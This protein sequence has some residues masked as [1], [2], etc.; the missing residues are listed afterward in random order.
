MVDARAAAKRISSDQRYGSLHGIP[1]AVKDVIDYRGLATTGKSRAFQ[2]NIAVR[3]AVVVRRLKAAGG[4]FFGKLACHE[5]GFAAPSLDLPWPPVRN[6]WDARLSPGGSSSG[7]AAA[8]SAGFVPAALGTDT[9]GSVRSPASSCGVVGLVPTP[10]LVSGVGVLPLSP[11]LDRVGVLAR[12]VEDGALVLRTLVGEPMG[13]RVA[14]HRGGVGVGLSGIRVGY[15]R[16]FHTIDCSDPDPSV[17]ASLE[18]AV[19]LLVE[20]GAEVREV[21]VRLSGRVCRGYQTI[22]LAEAW[23]LYGRRFA[24][25]RGDLG[26]AAYQRLS[27]GGAIGASEYGNAVGARRRLAREYLESTRE[28]DA[29]IC[30]SGMDTPGRLG[31][32]AGTAEKYARQGRTPFSVIGAP[33]LSLPSGRTVTGAPLGIQIAGRPYGDAV[34][35][36]VA[37]ALEGAMPWHGS[38]P[39][40]SGSWKDAPVRK[41]ARRRVREEA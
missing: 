2:R 41:P 33:A 20:L 7:S 39:T 24:R 1:Y 35:L 12:T 10:G 4:I 23:S 26:V 25:G 18:A 40:L 37:N 16:H 27:E 15:I 38:H 28:V 34:V 5:L 21:R 31:C 6:P 8:V 22:M 14:V 11:T 29:V 17:V 19:R 32:T 36:R 9:G 3:D 30:A 13:S